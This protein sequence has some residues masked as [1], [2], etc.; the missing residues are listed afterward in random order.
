MLFL[1]SAV[2]RIALFLATFFTLTFLADWLFVLPKELRLAIFAGGVAWLGYLIIKHAI[3]PMSMK[4]SDDELALAI[5]RIYPLGDGLISSIQLTRDGGSEH[6]NSPELMNFAL[7]YAVEKTE[8]I[9]FK[10]VVTS[11]H[12]MKALSIALVAVLTIG[13]FAFSSRGLA[14]IYFAR[15]VGLDTKWPRATQLM[16]LDFEGNKKVVASGDDIAISVNAKG[17]VPQKVTL[18]Y[19]FKSGERGA[20]RMVGGQD[21]AIFSYTFTRVVTPF[22]FWVE[23]GD[24]KTEKFYIETLIP[25]RL[26]AGHHWYEYPSYVGLL[27]TPEDKPE[28]GGD[29]KAPIGTIAKISFEFSSGLISAKLTLGSSEGEKVL[30]MEIIKNADGVASIVKAKFTITQASSSYSVAVTAEN[31]LANREPVRFPVIG[32]LDNAPMITVKDPTADEYIT[33]I[34]V[35]PLFI[36]TKDDYAVNDVSITHKIMSQ[37]NPDEKTVVFGPAENTP[38]NYGVKSIASLYNFDVSKLKPEIG[39]IIEYYYSASDNKM[40]SPNV[41][42]TKPYRFIIISVS[43][44]EKRL[45]NEIE[46]IKSEL[47]VQKKNQEGILS[48]ANEFMKK[49]S[50]T[51]TLSDIE[52]QEIKSAELDQNQIRQRLESIE[53]KLSR[54]LKQG[55]YNKVFDQKSSGRLEQVKGIL[56]EL[57]GSSA[58][59]KTGKIDSSANLL[60]QSSASKDSGERASYLEEASK[61]EKDI[62][63]DLQDALALLEEWATYQDVVRATREILEAQRKINEGI[64][65]K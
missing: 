13:F 38:S 47:R 63:M 39:S 52:K 44:L 18:Y 51:D 17:R 4:I 58:S 14:S 6:F 65:P 54:V 49:F 43:E 19:E 50:D 24:D 5:E 60:K 12:T 20:Q 2:S 53:K 41:T 32:V 57:T 22:S 30:P 11:R 42:K 25:P 27:N 9:D 56:S 59:A 61:S 31:G 29:L 40:P 21:K 64:K 10:N 33:D 16:V 35:R 3:Y 15:L 8:R 46:T 34:A 26:E 45:T 37:A 36:E 62:V 28:I 1:V 23:G 55:T 7:Q 48:R